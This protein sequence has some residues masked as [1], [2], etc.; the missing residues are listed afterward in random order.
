MPREPSK[1]R[2]QFDRSLPTSVPLCEDP[3]GNVHFVSGEHRILLAR[4]GRGAEP[5]PSN[6]ASPPMAGAGHEL[7]MSRPA[8]CESR[9]REGR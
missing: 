6:P 9:G 1:S 7:E 3:S 8:S 4:Y 2:G 5:E